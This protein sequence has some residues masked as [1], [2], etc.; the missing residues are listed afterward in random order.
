[1]MRSLLHIG[2]PYPGSA[3]RPTSTRRIPKLPRL[4][5]TKPKHVIFGPPF[6]DADA[7]VVLRSSDNVD[8][9]FHGALLSQA[10]PFFESKLSLFQPS[11][12]SSESDSVYE[13][14]P[15]SAFNPLVVHVLLEENSSVVHVLLSMLLA[16]GATL[17]PDQD[18]GKED[19]FAGDDIVRPTSLGDALTLINAAAKYD[20]TT[21]FSRAQS[22]LC[23]FLTLD[24]CVPIYA[25]AHR[26]NLHHETLSAARLTLQLPLYDVN[27]YFISCDPSWASD[28]AYSD[29]RKY[30]I[31]YAS[32]MERHLPK[33]FESSTELEIWVA[34]AV[35]QG[36]PFERRRC[37][38]TAE[39]WRETFSIGARRMVEDL[40]RSAQRASSPSW[41][42]P[43]ASGP[44]AAPCLTCVTCYALRRRAK[45]VEGELVE[46]ARRIVRVEVVPKIDVRGIF[47]DF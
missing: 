41:S 6:D 1:M 20:M 19:P 39:A 23:E 43:V 40:C 3:S 37:S 15:S 5:D 32:A 46:V 9:Y 14:H 31:A 17:S 24:T 7:D 34:H 42:F 25:T 45:D 28:P 16:D 29:I 10:S 13:T 4:C 21:V 44:G 12:V 33:V 27:E 26:F 35:C 22:F 36:S 8:F 18:V 11:P 38:N 30:R 2:T 47:P